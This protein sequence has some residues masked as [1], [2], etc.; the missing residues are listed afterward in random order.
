[1]VQLGSD[2]PGDSKLEDRL[3]HMT[4]PSSEEIRRGEG[5][6]KGGEERDEEEKEEERKRKRRKGEEMKA[7][8]KGR[9]KGRKDANRA[10]GVGTEEWRAGRGEGRVE[11]THGAAFLCPSE[12]VNTPSTV[13]LPDSISRDLTKFPRRG[14]SLFPRHGELANFTQRTKAAKVLRASI[15]HSFQ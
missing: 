14:S 5:R 9:R 1:M 7:W 10:E 6:Q 4:R 11:E 12:W 3:R 15:M 2:A 8:V 13:R